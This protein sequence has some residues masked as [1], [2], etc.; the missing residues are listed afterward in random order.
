MIQG[1]DML[2]QPWNAAMFCQIV[3]AFATETECKRQNILHH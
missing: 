1:H 3:A 2:G